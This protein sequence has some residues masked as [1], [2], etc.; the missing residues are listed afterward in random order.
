MNKLF[1]VL[2]AV[3]LSC[4]SGES[5]EVELRNNDVSFSATLKNYG[6]RI[7]TGYKVSGALKIINHS[8]NEVQYSNRDLFVKIIGEGESR[9]HSDSLSSPV[10][11]IDT[12]PIKPNATL[13]Q[14]VYWVLPPVKSLAAERVVLEWRN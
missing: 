8:T 14:E 10:I 7:Q 6:K 5:I 12:V 3:L 2:S 13:E 1:L 4:C 11:D 9:T